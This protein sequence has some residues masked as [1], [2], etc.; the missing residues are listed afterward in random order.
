MQNVLQDEIEQ[1]LPQIS[2]PTLIFW[3]DRDSFTPVKHAAIFASKIPNAQLKLLRK[4]GHRPYFTQ[5]TL[6]AENI[7]NFI[8]KNVA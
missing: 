6:L 3:G 2:V 4:E 8:Q 7:I 1:E 5:P